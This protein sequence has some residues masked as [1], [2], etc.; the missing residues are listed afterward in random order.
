MGNGRI[1]LSHDKAALVHEILVNNAVDSAASYSAPALSACAQAKKA[2][3]PRDPFHLSYYWQ[4]TLGKNIAK[5]LASTW[6]MT[7]HF[8]HAMEKPDNRQV[9][10]S[11]TAQRYNVEKWGRRSFEEFLK[12]SFKGV[13]GDYPATSI[14]AG[15]AGFYIHARSTKRYG[16]SVSGTVSLPITW[17]N[18][19]FKRGLCNLPLADDPLTPHFTLK[20]LSYSGDRAT[21]LVLKKAGGKVGKHEA[22]LAEAVKRDDKWTLT[23]IHPESVEAPVFKEDVFTEDFKVVKSNLPG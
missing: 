10:Y 5:T 3:N 12:G 4:T 15:K 2:I 20:C 13:G 7:P 23:H 19:V 18:S 16:L 21:L 14:E 9:E 8:F 1:R 11:R 6:S 22:R 17:Y